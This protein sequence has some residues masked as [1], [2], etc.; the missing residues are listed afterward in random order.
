LCCST[1]AFTVCSAQK[2]DGAL[3]G[4]KREDGDGDG[5]IRTSS[6]AGSVDAILPSLINATETSRDAGPALF[7]NV[8]A[9]H[10]DGRTCRDRLRDFARNML[11]RRE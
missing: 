2:S 6:V 9:R 11:W 4:G 1:P 8:G 5:R 3:K 7:E 10:L